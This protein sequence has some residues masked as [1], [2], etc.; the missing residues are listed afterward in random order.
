MT[1]QTAPAVILVHGFLDSGE[2][3][4]PVL[5]LLGPSTNGWSIPDLPGME[6]CGTQKDRFR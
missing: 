6:D 3:W 5:K 1:G 2:V 4:R